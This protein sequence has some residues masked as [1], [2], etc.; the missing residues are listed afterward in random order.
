VEG[1]CVDGR[2]ESFGKFY[3]SIHDA[4]LM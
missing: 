4:H 3:Q 1:E 2:V